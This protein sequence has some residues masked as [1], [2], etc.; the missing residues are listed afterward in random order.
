MDLAEFRLIFGDRDSCAVENNKTST[1]ST[2]VNGTDEALLEVVAS[3]VLVLEY[4]AI[5]V[6]CLLWLRRCLRL[7]WS[8]LVDLEFLRGFRV[9]V[10]TALVEFERVSHLAAMA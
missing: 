9:P 4:G 5:P 8:P 1:G 2:L 3:T 7:G 10:D 6:V